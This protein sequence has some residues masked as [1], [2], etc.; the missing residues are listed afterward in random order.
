M[1]IEKKLCVLHL[2]DVVHSSLEEEKVFTA[3]ESCAFTPIETELILTELQKT[4]LIHRSKEGILLSEEGLVVLQFF[5]DRLPLSI[6][7][8]LEKLVEEEGP[9]FEW[10]HQYDLEKQR[11]FISYTLQGEKLLAMDFFLEPDAYELLL[12]HLNNLQP[13]DFS[14]LKMFFLKE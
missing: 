2:L 6:Q 13:D 4:N 7:E 1:D 11:L 14:K 12:P 9:Q 8:K 10:I 5:R 3:L